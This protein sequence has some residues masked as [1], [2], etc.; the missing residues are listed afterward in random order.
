MSPDVIAILT[1]ASV[2]VIT[3]APHGTHVFQVLDGLL[4]GALKKLTSG[5]ET[6]NEESGTVAFII[7]L[8]HD[9][10]QTI[11]EVNIWGAF[12]AIDFSYDITQN[13]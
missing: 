9:F 7:K 8:Y 2:K 5:L 1:K 4:F 13:P 3:F 10:K 12:S 11:V 6:R